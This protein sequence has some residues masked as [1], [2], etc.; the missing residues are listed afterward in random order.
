METTCTFLK[1]I[2][3]SAPTALLRQA[4]VNNRVSRSR[5][6]VAEHKTLTM[7]NSYF[8]SLRAHVRKVSR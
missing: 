3:R 4:N 2:A 7:D 1:R 6:E 5:T 8:D